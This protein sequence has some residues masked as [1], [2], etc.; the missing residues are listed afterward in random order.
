MVHVRLYGPLRQLASQPEV[1]VAVEQGATLG[2]VLQRV[3]GDGNCLSS[4]R[5]SIICGKVSTVMLNGSNC[6]FRQG[7]DTPVQ[8]GDVIELLP[9][10]SGG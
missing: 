5:G 6:A 4:G 10:V 9:I 1:E 3:C 8:D 7:L 2:T